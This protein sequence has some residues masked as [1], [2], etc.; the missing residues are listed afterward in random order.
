MLTLYSYYRSSAA[1]RVRIALNLKGLDYSQIAVDLVAG[2][3]QQPDYRQVNPQGLVPFLSL[4]GRSGIAQSLAIIEWLEEQYPQPALLPGDSIERARTRA[5]S[6]TIACDIHPLNNLRV[7]RYLINDM[8][9]SEQQKLQWYHHWIKS[10]FDSLEATV[11]ATPFALGEQATLVDVM[12]VPQ[13]Y[14]ALRFQTPMDDYP[15]IMKVYHHCLDQ[16]AFFQ[17]SP[18]QQPDAPQ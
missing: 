18:E 5:L 14:N 9:C 6:G 1:Y 3:Q 2:E 8:N 15:N 4:N 7:Q 16:P 13:V 11:E 10:G 12:L 17:A